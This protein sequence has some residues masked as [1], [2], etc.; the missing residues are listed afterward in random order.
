MNSKRDV[1]RN[2]ARICLKVFRV[3]IELVNEERHSVKKM[4]K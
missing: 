4:L 2:K 1:A 3:R